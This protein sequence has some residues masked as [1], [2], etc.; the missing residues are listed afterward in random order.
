[1]KNKVIKYLIYASGEILLV[2]I[3]IL[4]ALQINT[5]NENHKKEQKVITYLKQFTNDLTYDIET[6]TTLINTNEIKI[7]NI[8]SI[9]LFSITKKELSQTE[10]IQFIKL[11][12]SLVFESYFIPEKSTYDQLVASSHGDFFQNEVLRTLLFRYYSTNERNEKNNEISTQL[13]QHHYF[14]EH[15]TNTILISSENFERFGVKGLKRPTIDF[16]NLSLNTHYVSAITRRRKNARNQNNNYKRIKSLA[17]NLLKEV[18][19]ELDLQEVL[20]P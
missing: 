5:M 11:H 6:L 8:D 10:M 18:E 1:M 7:K 12:E 15:I 9:Q 17:E 14:T 4:I 16:Q 13:Y 3:G 2:V 19:E 20:Y